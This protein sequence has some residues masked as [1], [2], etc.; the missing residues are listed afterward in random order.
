MGEYEVPII[1]YGHTGD[2]NVHLHPICVNM[3]RGEWDKRLPRLMSDLYRAGISFAGA[4]SGEHGIGFDKKAYLSIGMDSALLD[5]MTGIKKAFDPNNIL[6]PGKI[7]D[8]EI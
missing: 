8:L 4:I 1:V 6:N 7:F 3:N 2:G 5:I